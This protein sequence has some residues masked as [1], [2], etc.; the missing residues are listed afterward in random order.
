MKKFLWAV[1]L[2]VG[3]VA[4]NEVAEKKENTEESSSQ[5]VVKEDSLGW[6]NTQILENPNN[7]ELYMAKARY[8]LRKGN[9]E[10]AVQ[11]ANKA[12]NLDTTN[13]RYS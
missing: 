8:M 5:E 3:V 11:E 1:L 7:P 12:I 9:V 6:I 13:V 4:C 2:F 10:N